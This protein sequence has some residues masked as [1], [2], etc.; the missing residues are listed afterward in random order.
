MIIITMTESGYYFIFKIGNKQKF[1]C[2]V[3]SEQCAAT[4]SDGHACGRKVAIGSPYCYV[5][6][7]HQEHF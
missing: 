6:L 7:L 4:K 2:K 1:S 5:H 3:Q